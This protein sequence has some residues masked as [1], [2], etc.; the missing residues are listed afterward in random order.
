MKRFIKKS[1]LFLILF[2]PVLLV[3]SALKTNLHGVYTLKKTTHTLITGDSHVQ[4]A[5]VTEQAR[6][7]RNVAVDSEGYLY[8]LQ[9]LK[10]ILAVNPQIKTVILGLSYHN[11]S[12]YYDTYMIGKEARHILPRYIDLFSY[13]ELLDLIRANPKLLRPALEKFF[14]LNHDP[15][16]YIGKYIN[17]E[18]GKKRFRQEVMESRVRSQFYEGNRVRGISKVNIAYLQRIVALC[19][20]QKITLVFIKTPLHPA[21]RN[22]I[23]KPHVNAYD[24]LI[25]CLDLP[26]IDFSGLE[27][28]DDD[29]L[30]DGDHVNAKGALITTEH[31]LA[32]YPSELSKS[33]QQMQ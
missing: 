23:P 16:A 3:Y 9:K 4:C 28:A 24:K 26:V 19:K 30:P 6:G 8:S 2:L 12:D 22:K 21:Y 32:H 29:F 5:L 17:S 14:R 13:S 20:L 33:I 7:V 18:T 27:L 15:Y 25:K 31:F 1:A 11:L 10:K